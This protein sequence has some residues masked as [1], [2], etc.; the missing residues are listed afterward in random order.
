MC[1]VCGAFPAVAIHHR[2]PRKLGGS[3]RAWIAQVPN[4]LALCGF[5]H[6]LI[7]SRR[8]WAYEQGYL[9]H[10]NQIPLETPVLY[11][12]RRVLLLQDGSLELLV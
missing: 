7:E 1:E 10:D 3:R 2:L 9:L 12:G 5:D 11:R 6:D 8:T 4:G